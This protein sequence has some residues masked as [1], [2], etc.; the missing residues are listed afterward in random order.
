MI[1]LSLRPSLFCSPEEG[2]FWGRGDTED[3]GWG[4][5][6]PEPDGQLLSIN[7][8]SQRLW[9]SR[10]IS[11]HLRLKGIVACDWLICS[12]LFWRQ[13]TDWVLWHFQ[14]ETTDKHLSPD[15]QYVPRVLFVGK[16][17]TCSHL[18][19]LSLTLHWTSQ[20]VTLH[21][22]CVLSVLLVEELMKYSLTLYTMR[23]LKSAS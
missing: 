4:L 19:A 3:P 22:L 14:Y 16:S 15:G 13:S 8:L 18:M 2:F 9:K 1:D 12:V 20:A 10:I 21:F 23:M 17:S 5:H 11:K 6:R 7:T